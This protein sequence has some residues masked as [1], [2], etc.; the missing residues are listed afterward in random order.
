MKATI[1]I[2]N[3]GDGFLAAFT[4]QRQEFVGRGGS[5]SE[6]LQDLASELAEVEA[7]H[8]AEM[9]ERRKAGEFRDRLLHGYV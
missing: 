7:V 6:A 1:D 9:Q 2:E 8:D 5:L 4:Y 3:D